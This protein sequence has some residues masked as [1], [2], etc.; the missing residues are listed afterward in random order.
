MSVV[1][2]L[3]SVYLSTFSVRVL[4]LTSR[5]CCCC[6]RRRR[7]SSSLGFIDMASITVM[8]LQLHNRHTRRER[9]TQIDARV[10]DQH[11]DGGSSSSSEKKREGVGPALGTKQRSPGVVNVVLLCLLTNDDLVRYRCL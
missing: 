3:A 4:F 7:S 11:S 1:A 5:C 10:C 6:C 2:N 8:V 9:D